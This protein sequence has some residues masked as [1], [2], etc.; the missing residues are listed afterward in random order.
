MGLRSLMDDDSA[1]RVQNVVINALLESFYDILDR[2][3]KG[4][5]L[6]AAGLPELMDAHLDPKE[7]TDF[8]V[9]RKIIDA[10]NML[11]QFS[12]F[13][14]YE[15]GRKFAIYLD[16]TGTGIE[17]II[18]NIKKWIQADWDISVTRKD[19]G[20][21]SLMI[22]VEQCPFCGDCKD[23]GASGC[24]TCD[25]LRGVFTMSAEKTSRHPI[26]CSEQDHVFT[27]Q[28]KQGGEKK[29]G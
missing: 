12:E 9:F 8:R 2:D 23:P 11:L 16:P 26:A 6:R 24:L 29:N 3:G 27:L 18:H 5:I 15:I 10:M 1:P 13:I 21:R 28:I 4:S 25:F 7:F 22:R 20:N 17:A 19:A 14:A